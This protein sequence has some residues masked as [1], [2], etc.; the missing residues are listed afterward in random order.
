MQL[1]LVLPSHWNAIG[2]VMHDCSSVALDSIALQQ[3]DCACVKWTLC[4]G[5]SKRAYWVHGY[6]TIYDQ[7]VS[8]H[9]ILI[10]N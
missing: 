8:V 6:N 1:P 5:S 7:S 10:H 3:G 4:H 9:A 2:V